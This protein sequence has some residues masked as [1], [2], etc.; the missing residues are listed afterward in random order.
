MANNYDIE[1]LRSEGMQALAN[2]QEYTLAAVQGH[3]A[4][5]TG[6]IAGPGKLFDVYDMDAGLNLHTLGGD[7]ELFKTAAATMTSAVERQRG[8]LKELMGFWEGDGS[9]AAN[10]FLTN[11][12]ATAAAVSNE[13]TQVSKGLDGL[14][15]TLYKLAGLKTEATTNVDDLVTPDRQHFDAAV[16]TYKYG[17]GDKPEADETNEYKIGPHVKNNI[18]GQW[19]P[20]MQNAKDKFGQAYDALINGLKEDLPPGFKLPNDSGD[21][22]P[23]GNPRDGKKEP[24]DKNRDGVPDESVGSDGKSGASTGHGTNTGGVQGSATPAS[25]MSNYSQG[26]PNAGQTPGQQQ[27]Q[28]QGMDPSQM[29][30]GMTS[31]LTGALTSIGQAASGIVSAITEGLSNIPFDQMGG[32]HGPGDDKPEDKFDGK[33]DEA[34]D[35]SDKKDTDP[36]AKMAAAKEAAIHEARSDAGG[37]FATDG[38]PASGPGIQ[39]AGAGGLDAATPAT[40]GQTVPG[41]PLGSTPLGSVPPSTASTPPAQPAAQMSPVTPPPAAQQHTEPPQQR[42]PAQPQATGTDAGETPC[43]IAADELP[44]A[45][46]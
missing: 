38:K 44:K 16:A 28:G 22:D 29:V 14:R 34:A 26:G 37:T 17:T 25:G 24:E 35:K 2:S 7:L 8:Q 19:L 9:Q 5:I 20:A 27:G 39:L 30:S 33:A 31:A 41:T 1:S 40:P 42:P 11:H 43:E 3:G 15:E 21:V 46:R 12:N 4:A 18:E 13:F 23:E 32:E 36:D 45:G 10:D 6:E